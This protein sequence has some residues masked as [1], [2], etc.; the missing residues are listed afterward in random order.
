[1]AKTTSKTWP[2][3]RPRSE[4]ASAAARSGT[5]RTLSWPTSPTRRSPTG[6]PG[7][8]DAAAPGLDGM[9]NPNAPTGGEVYVSATIQAE[10]SI[11][12]A[13]TL[14]GFIQIQAGISA[15]AIA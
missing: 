4:S 3:G 7:S 1:M 5:S 10:I 8:H 15:Q 6:T 11:G 14:T 13:L 9:R 12:G 2:T